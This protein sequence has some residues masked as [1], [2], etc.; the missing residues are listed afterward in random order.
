MR[1]ERDRAAAAHARAQSVLARERRLSAEGAIS[2]DEADVADTTMRTAA[3]TLKAAEFAVARAEYELASARA[4]LRQQGSPGRVSEVAAPVDGVVLKRMRES[5]A[6]VQLGEPLVEIGNP[7]RLEVVAD[8]LSTDAVRVTPGQRV[9][10]EQW[11]GGATLQ[12]LVRRVDPS[13]FTKVSALGVEEQ[14]VNV[15]IDFADPASAARL[16]D[17]YR[18]EVRIVVWRAEDV[19]T[20]PVGALFRHGDGWAVFKIDGDRVRLH[21]V[22]AG[23]RNSLD[24][25]VRGLAEG[26]RVVL[27]PPDTLEDGDRVV[28]RIR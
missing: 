25:E 17:A 26:Q 9:L 16:G 5:E 19:L 11:G 8:L 12:G 7:D 23:H 18:V 6:I 20:V 21:A 1:A 4:R 3:E 27:H 15:V 2:R 10:L 28:G 14:R 13:G 22:T 24:A